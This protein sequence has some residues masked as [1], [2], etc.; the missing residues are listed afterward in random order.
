M[1]PKSIWAWL[2]SAAMLIA[3]LPFGQAQASHAV[4]EPFRI[5]YEQYQG[6]RVLGYP[7]TGLVETNGYPAQYFEKGRLEDHRAEPNDAG[8]DFMYGRLTAELIERAGR[9]S[10]SGT[11]LTYAD[12]GRHQQSDLHAA[13]NGFAGGVAATPAGTFIPYDALLRPAYG[14]IVP[15]Y[16]WE[17]IMRSDL[18]PGGWMHDIGLPMTDAF[19]IDAYKSGKL[20]AIT[21]QAF[22]RAVLTY[23]AQNPTD[24]QV[25][26][27]NI[28]TDAVRI[29]PSPN[30][31]EMPTPNARV[32]LPIHILARVGRPGETVSVHLHWEH[33]ANI[34][35]TYTILRG[36]DG[37]GL[38]LET[39]DIPPEY[40]SQHPW[41]QT[42]QLEIDNQQGSILARQ[43]VTV[44]HPDDPDTHM[45]RLYWTTTTS[46]EAQA[47]P[48]PVS[49]APEVAALDQLLWGPRAQ[50]PMTFT[51][52]LPT[53]AQVLAFPGRTADWGPRVTLRSFNLTD[54][55]A[56]ADFSKEL[57]AYGGEAR[58]A[59]LIHAQITRTLLEFPAVQDV[60]ITIEG[61][62]DR[63]LEPRR[64][65]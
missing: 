47:Q 25:E 50:T 42:A 59:S 2:T 34:T 11:P 48:V 8:W 60:V 6:M 5:Y 18:F 3:F 39:L 62:H 19:Q 61:Q 38:L 7:I 9:T 36:E 54:G 16:F 33:G 4:A 53:A 13:P 40:R 21:V 58:R 31:I 65:Q 37:R 12:L 20:R 43:T 22:E 30:V 15:A 14:Y 49:S 32:T 41:T 1:S 44:L 28:G 17:Y 27:A 51:T 35:Q 56:V 23:D 24:W 46:I 64:F 45:V 10:L 52:A 26:R 55:I 63:L 29:L 57:A